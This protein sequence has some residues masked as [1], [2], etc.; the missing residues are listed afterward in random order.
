MIAAIL[1]DIGGP[2]DTEVAR[3]SVRLGQIP[4]IGLG[5]ALAGFDCLAR[6]VSKSSR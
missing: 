5:P 2:I 3:L 6:A 1:F 4:E